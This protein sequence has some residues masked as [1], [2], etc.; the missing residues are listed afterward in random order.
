MRKS[1]KIESD[2]IRSWGN[3]EKYEDWAGVAGGG[4]EER[5]A[6]TETDREGDVGK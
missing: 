2:K 1:G 3:R 4:D 5:E 6:E